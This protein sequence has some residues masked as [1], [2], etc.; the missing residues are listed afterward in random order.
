M[1][2][3]VTFNDFANAL[4]KHRRSFTQICDV[5]VEFKR[6]GVRPKPATCSI[7]LKNSHTKSLSDVIYRGMG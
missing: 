2:N 4:V 7:L 5:V 3:Q 1:S 6:R